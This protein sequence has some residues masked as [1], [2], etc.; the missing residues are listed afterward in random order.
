MTP[1][2]IAVDGDHLKTVKCLVHNKA[3][4]T[5]KDNE[6]VSIQDYGRSIDAADMC[7]SFVGTIESSIY[8]CII[9]VRNLLQNINS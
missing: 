7:L 3:D 9:T 8:K 4:I 5:K 6:G 2:H 1:L